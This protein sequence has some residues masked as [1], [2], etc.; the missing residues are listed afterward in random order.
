MNWSWET[1]FEMNPAGSEGATSVFFQ[2]NL[3]QVLASPNY[4]YPR[5]FRVVP[6]VTSDPQAKICINN[7]RQIRIAK[8]LWQRDYEV[9]PIATPID[10][11][12]A[13]YF[14]HRT[15]PF[16]SRGRISELLD[17]SYEI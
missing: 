11:Y 14:P 5:F 16:L 6:Y 17:T 8:L 9:S 1:D 13:P 3:S 15:L 4:T 12:L 7:L 2:T 10:A